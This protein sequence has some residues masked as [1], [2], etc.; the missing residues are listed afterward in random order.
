MDPATL[1]IVSALTAGATALTQGFATEAIK[2]AYKSLK[3]LLLG[4]MKRAT[5]T[6]GALETNPASEP[7]QRMLA[8]QLRGS[9]ISP[10]VKQAA[11]ALLDQIQEL[12]GEPRAHALLDF[13]ILDAAKNFELSADDF[14]G[15]L[16]RARHA[17]F[18]GDVKMS[19]SRQTGTNGKPEKN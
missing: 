17:K 11:V 5:S 8:E 2:D 1:T 18:G 3:S 14:A 15:P 9:N 16:L 6:V 7:E 12:R 13:D 4:H 10:D 19:I